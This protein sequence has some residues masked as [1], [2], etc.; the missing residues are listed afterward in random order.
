[1]VNS[2]VN[3]SLISQKIKKTS[4]TKSKK[5]TVFN[6]QSDSPS[7]SIIVC[8][9]RQNCMKNV[10]DNYNRQ[11]YTNKEMIII[12]NKDDMKLSEWEKKAALFSNV[13]VFKLDEKITLGNCMNYGISQSKNEIIAKFDDD[14]YYGPKY[15]LDSIK[16]FKNHDTHIVGKAASFVYFKKSKVLAIRSPYNENKY[17]RHMDGPTMLIKKEVFDKVKFA[18]IPRGIDTRFSKDCIEKGFKIYS[19]NR[20]HHVYMRSESSDEHTWKI[21]DKNLLKWCKIVHHNIDDYT[22]FADI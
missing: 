8:T 21:S 6:K 11:I 4:K 20:F 14:D 16:A 1:M 12:L 3:K 9:M 15:L 2:P 19:T 17:V 13:R 22:K 7:V 10:F 5:A 18:D